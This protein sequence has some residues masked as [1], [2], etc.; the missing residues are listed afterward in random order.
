MWS[1]LLC[2]YFEIGE[3][4]FGGLFF[5]SNIIWVHFMVIVTLRS[6]FSCNRVRTI[7]VSKWVI[8]EFDNVT[9]PSQNN[10]IFYTHE[11]YVVRWGFQITVSLERNGE[12]SPPAGFKNFNY[13][14]KS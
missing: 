11:S 3:F 10:G 12:I 8:K 6:S 2:F 4:I 7:S 5:I 14:S 1:S 13:P 9:V